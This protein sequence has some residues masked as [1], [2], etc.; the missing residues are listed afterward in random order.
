M[1]L[2]IT[3]SIY[4]FLFILVTYCHG[5]EE[6]EEAEPSTPAR[7]FLKRSSLSLAEEISVLCA[8]QTDISSYGHTYQN[9]PDPV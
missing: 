4:K 8:R 2:Y 1:R 5:L 7:I 6:Q 3:W 9:I